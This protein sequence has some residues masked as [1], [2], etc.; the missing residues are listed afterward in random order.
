M[1]RWSRRGMP[2]RGEGDSVS[3]RVGKV[4]RR[5]GLFSSRRRAFLTVAGSLSSSG[6]FRFRRG[7]LSGVF[8]SK[9]DISCLLII[10]ELLS[11]LKVKSVPSPTVGAN[12]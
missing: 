11:S 10:L 8:S 6:S 12:C 9:F 7:L 5:D 3:P 4:D 2:R 1:A